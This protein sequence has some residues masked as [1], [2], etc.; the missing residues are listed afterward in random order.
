MRWG[1]PV[2]LLAWLILA[3]G[4]ARSREERPSMP[5]D[6]KVLMDSMP[7]GIPE[8]SMA[9]QMKRAFEGESAR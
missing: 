8:D 9:A 6:R 1:G 3:G 7:V 2:V 4:C 5:E